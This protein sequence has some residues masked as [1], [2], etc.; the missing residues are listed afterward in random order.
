MNEHYSKPIITWELLVAFRYLLC[1][2]NIDLIAGDKVLRDGIKFGTLHISVRPVA[3]AAYGQDRD[4]FEV[5]ATVW[6]EDGI[7]ADHVKAEAEHMITEIVN[8][9]LQAQK[10]IASGGLVPV[11]DN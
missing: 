4:G 9:T 3:G 5:F 2:I 8:L 10:D 11:I 1:I 7:G 6:Y